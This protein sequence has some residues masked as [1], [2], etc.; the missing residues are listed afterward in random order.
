MEIEI[1]DSPELA[2]RWNLPVTW[3]REHVRT[4]Y[5]DP[6]PHLEFGRYVR[7]RWGSPELDAWLMKKTVK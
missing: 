2:K 3:V 6:I 5:S 7:F 1:I 4:R